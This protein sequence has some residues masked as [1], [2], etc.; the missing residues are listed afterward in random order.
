MENKGKIK[1]KT[2][3]FRHKNFGD[4]S[5]AFLI[6]KNHKKGKESIFKCYKNGTFEIDG[7]SGDQIIWTSCDE[8]GSQKGKLSIFETLFMIFFQF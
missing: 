1:S 6:C 8:Q 3:L 2:G 4:F 5:D 7:K